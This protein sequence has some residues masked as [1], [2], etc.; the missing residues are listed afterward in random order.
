V[1]TKWTLSP[2][3]SNTLQVSDCKIANTQQ[4]CTK[5]ETF[6]K[7]IILNYSVKFKVCAQNWQLWPQCKLLF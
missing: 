2:K 4:I 7:T 6:V 5:F 3:I 1:L